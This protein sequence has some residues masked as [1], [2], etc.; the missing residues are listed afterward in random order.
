MLFNVIFTDLWYQIP[1]KTEIIHEVVERIYHSSSARARPIKPALKL[2]NKIPSDLMSTI[3]HGKNVELKTR[4]T[5]NHIFYSIAYDKNKLGCFSY[6]GKIKGV[7]A[8]DILGK[9]YKFKKKHRPY[10]TWQECKPKSKRTH[11]S[12]RGGQTFHAVEYGPFYR[13]VIPILNDT[14]KWR[15]KSLTKIKVL[16]K[17]TYMYMC[18]YHTINIKKCFRY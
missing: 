11:D 8:K 13:L 10:V 5:N 3:M 9:K 4:E 2:P 15:I 14:T 18:M 12:G 7:S 17:G 6:D 16:S 1:V